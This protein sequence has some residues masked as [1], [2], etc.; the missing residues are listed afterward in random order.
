[1]KIFILLL[2][3][4]DLAS[5]MTIENFLVDKLI[6]KL[7]ND[8][9]CLL[10]DNVKQIFTNRGQDYCS[11]LSKKVCTK[12]EKDC[13]WDNNKCIKKIKSTSS[14]GSQPCL[15]GCCYTGGGKAEC[16]AY[17]SNDYTHC[18]SGT[19]GGNEKTCNSCPNCKWDSYYGECYSK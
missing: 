11:Q 7:Q 10:N 5:F 17:D 8:P 19:F 3:L 18:N 2:I 1:M 16:Y 13:L 6:Y 9:P 4:F 15:E 12:C 14:C